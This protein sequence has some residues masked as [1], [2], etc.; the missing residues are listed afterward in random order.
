VAERYRSSFTGEA[1]ALFDQIGYT[2]IRANKETDVQASYEFSDGG[3][4]GLSLLLQVTNLTNEPFESEQVSGLPN[5]VEV[6]RPL[7][8]DTWGR[9]VLLGVN[10][11][12]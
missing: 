9:T 1:V 6:A 7:E 11:A 5:G 8:Y 4:K 2:R 3:L 12:L 10:Y